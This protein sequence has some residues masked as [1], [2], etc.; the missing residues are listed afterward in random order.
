MHNFCSV[1]NKHGK[2]NRICV[3]GKC[4][5]PIVFSEPEIFHLLDILRMSQSPYQQTDITTEG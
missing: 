4:L 2:T 1:Q 5:I 3:L